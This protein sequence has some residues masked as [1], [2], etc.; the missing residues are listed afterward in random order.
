VIIGLIEA[1]TSYF[2][3]PALKEAVLFIGL[4]VLLII[5]PSGLFGTFEGRIAN[6]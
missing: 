1:L 4:I 2:W 6:E 5:K 3:I